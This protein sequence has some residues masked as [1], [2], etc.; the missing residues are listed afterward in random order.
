MRSH[1][2]KDYVQS[3]FHEKEQISFIDP[4]RGN[5]VFTVFFF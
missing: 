4:T 3:N 1:Y 2:R 5:S